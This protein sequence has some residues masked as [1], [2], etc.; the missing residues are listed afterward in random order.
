[1]LYVKILPLEAITVNKKINQSE[2]GSKDCL[3]V[4]KRVEKSPSILSSFLLHQSALRGYIS[5]FVRRSHDIDDVAQEAFLRAYRTEQKRK[6]DHPKSFLFRIAHN[7][8]ITELTKKSSQIID[9]IEDIDNSAVIWEG[10][11]AEDEAI[12]RQSLD[13]HYQAVAKLPEQC[14]RVFLM[15]KVHGMTYKEISESLG[16]AVSTVEKHMAKGVRLS[17]KY[18]DELEA[19]EGGGDVVKISEAELK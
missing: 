19:C 13:I 11:T 10:G 5:R 14:R 8:A 1:M 16:I 7:V 9:Y 4:D 3:E 18:V 17:A 2:R 6:I 12:A 15:R